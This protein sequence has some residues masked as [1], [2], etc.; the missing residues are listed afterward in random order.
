MSTYTVEFGDDKVV[1]TINA[2]RTVSPFVRA[3]YTKKWR[4]AFF[5]LARAQ[6]VPSLTAVTIEVYPLQARKP[7]AD[8][9]AHAPA[10]KAAIDGLVD[11]G[12]MPDDTPEYLHS[13]TFHPP[14]KGKR[15]GL[16][17]AIHGT[18]T[19]PCKAPTEETP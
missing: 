7:L 14:V 8:V 12:V 10:A 4:E 9:V 3:R 18:P 2:E 11:A 1:P 13:V 19:P 5:L 6:R 16:R 15:N 17:L